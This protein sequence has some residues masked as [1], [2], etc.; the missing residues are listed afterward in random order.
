MPPTT[1]LTLVG[2]FNFRD[3]GGLPRKHG[4]RIRPGRVFRSDTPQM[5]TSTD[6]E[7]LVGDCGI[8]TVVD[9]RLASEISEEGRGPLGACHQV[10]YINSPL[11]MASTE[12]IPPGQILDHLYA[13]CLASPSLPQAIEA[14][15]EQVDHPILFHCAA[16]KDRT[17]VVAAMLLALLGVE[18][19][20]I[21]ADYMRSRDAMPR[22]IERFKSWPRYREHMA[23]MP[24]EVYGVAESTIRRLLKAI[25]VEHGGAREWAER[26][27]I[28]PSSL[29]RLEQH[30]IE[31]G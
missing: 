10:H 8:R 5:L 3:L 25:E 24:P 27:G 7:V 18:P 14:I 30:L 15:A 26:R 31:T 4:G 21:V 12:G 1:G 13:R 19:D 29:M 20:A 2:A 9:L 28:A 17:G 11:E 22:I 23:T 6:T 16:G